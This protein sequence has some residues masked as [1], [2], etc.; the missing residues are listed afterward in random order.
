MTKILGVDPGIHGALSLIDT[1]VWS[2]AI[3]DM[4]F[5]PGVGGK[6]SVSATRT[7][8]FIRA[9]APDYSFIESVFSSP[10]MGVVS[11]FAFGRSLGILEGACAS[12]SILEKPRPQEWKTSTKTPKDKNQAR[13][14]AMQLF[15][16]HAELFAR[17]KDDGR[18]ESALIALYGALRIQQ[19]PPRPLSFVEFPTCAD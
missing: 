10:Q 1:S 9:A 2:L 5:E 13:A 7:A 15:P 19:V 17:V 12:T 6:N 18:A 14:R 8:Q 3:I 11:S 16:R 4:P